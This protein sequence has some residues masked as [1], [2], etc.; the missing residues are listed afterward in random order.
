MEITP[1]PLVVT[2]NGFITLASENRHFGLQHQRRVANKGRLVLVQ[3]L[4][5][6][7]RKTGQMLHDLKN[8]DNRL[9]SL[10]RIKMVKQEAIRIE[11]IVRRSTQEF[12]RLLKMK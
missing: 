11:I 2:K 12:V 5:E 7:I 10:I 9:K 1:S 4:V 6:L 3:M 8:I